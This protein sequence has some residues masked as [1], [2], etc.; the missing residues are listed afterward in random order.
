MADTLSE[1]DEQF[2]EP[3]LHTESQDVALLL[4][5][6]TIQLNLGNDDIP[7]GKKH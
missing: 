2:Y 4:I 3:D 6:D 1:P 5:N 7:V